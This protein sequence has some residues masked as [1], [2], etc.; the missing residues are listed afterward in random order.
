MAE[1]SWQD[2][3]TQ[4]SS[5]RILVIGDMVADEHIFTRASGISREAPL[6]VLHFIDR[7][8]VPGGATN[9]ARNARALG[10]E[11]WVTGV[12]GND[13]VGHDLREMLEDDRIHCNETL[14]R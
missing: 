1:P 7:K 5:Q 13:Q 4:F 9:V 14:H 12:I 3:L 6:P 10:A 8:L 2:A 11:V